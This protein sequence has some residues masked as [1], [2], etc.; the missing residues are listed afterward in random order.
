MIEIKVPDMTCGHCVSTIIKAVQ[1]LDA[2]AKVDT[3]L[4]EHRVR[5][6][7]KAS[8]EALIHCIAEA[9]FTPQAV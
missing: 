6:E 1:A 3:V 5:V 8:K 4:A 7:S 2:S 9:G